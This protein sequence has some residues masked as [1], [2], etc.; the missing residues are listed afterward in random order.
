MRKESL[1]F[2]FAGSWDGA[3]SRELAKGRGGN[4]VLVDRIFCWSPRRCPLAVAMDFGRYW[5]IKLVVI[6]GQDWKC[7]LLMAR[8][9]VET[10]GLK[11][12]AWRNDT[13]SALVADV[14][15]ALAIG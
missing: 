2:G 11:A 5:R 7:P 8:T 15:M 12:A 3:T 9:R 1:D 4:I 10:A 14:R 13:R 6:P